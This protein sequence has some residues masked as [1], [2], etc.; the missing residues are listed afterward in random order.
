MAHV[1]EACED[2][3]IRILIVVCIGMLA[4]HVLFDRDNLETAILD[5][6]SIVVAVVL[7]V[8]VG[9]FNNYQKEKQY[10]SLYR[11]SEDNKYVLVQRNNSLITIH[12]SELVSGDVVVINE[13]MEIPADGWVLQSHDIKADESLITGENDTI[14]KES[15][16]KALQYRRNM[17]EHKD[18]THSYREVPSPVVLAGSKILSGSG[19]FVV[20]QVGKKSSLGRMGDL[21]LGENDP[22]PLQIKLNDV[23]EAIGKY[24]TVAAISIVGVLFAKF[25]LARL[26]NPTAEIH[27]SELINYILIGLS[28]AVAS[29]PEGL[30]LAVTIAL[31]YSAKKMLKDSNLVRKLDACETMGGA[32]AICSDK[33]GTLTQNKMTVDCIYIPNLENKST[34]AVKGLPFHAFAPQTLG[35]YL[36]LNFACNNNSN[37]EP[38]SGSKTNI[39]LLELLRDNNIDFKDLRQKYLTEDAVVFDFSSTRKRSGVIINHGGQV[40]L[41]KGAAEFILASCTQMHLSN[42]TVIEINEKQRAKLNETIEGKYPRFFPIS[43]LSSFI[44]HEQQGSQSHWLRLQEDSSWRR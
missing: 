23:A 43:N 42:G 39:A 11:V 5:S 35:T 37:L 44:R 26:L 18:Q 7:C 28:T 17:Q 30:P 27:Y 36:S 2:L 34:I 32:D 24:G 1:K 21:I 20:L 29:I 6:I 25:F 19:K 22:T 8:G 15:Y 16:D 14:N 10:L 12:S 3:L 38:Q 33:T 31:A 9:S 4:V 40:L 41:E 13:G